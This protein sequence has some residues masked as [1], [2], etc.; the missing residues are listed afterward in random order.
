MLHYYAKRF[1]APLLISPYKKE[2]KF[3]VY[4]VIDGIPTSE[5]RNSED[6]TLQFS[7]KENEES[8]ST[9]KGR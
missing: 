8:Q 2:D 7:P 9:S 4:I 6:N 1:F 3:Y 5:H